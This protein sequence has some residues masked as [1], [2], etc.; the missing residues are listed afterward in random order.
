M[1]YTYWAM[2]GAAALL[3]AVSGCKQKKAKDPDKEPAVAGQATAAKK[4]PLATAGPSKSPVKVRRVDTRGS[5]TASPDKVVDARIFFKDCQ[6]LGAVG[7][8]Q[9]YSRGVTVRGPLMRASTGVMG[10]HQ[11]SLAVG[12]GTW[13]GG[14]WITASFADK[15]KAAKSKA[16]KKGDTVIIKCQLSALSPKTITLRDCT[17]GR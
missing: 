17:L 7:A 3:V 1:K 10:D 6:T 9:R 16:P 13:P 12:E 4:G 11:L 5:M 8:L 14:K 2:L 15:G